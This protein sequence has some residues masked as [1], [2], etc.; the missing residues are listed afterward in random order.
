MKENILNSVFFFSFRFVLEWTT[1]EKKPKKEKEKCVPAGILSE[2]E[3]VNSMLRSETERAEDTTY[4][5]AETE[6]PNKFPQEEGAHHSIPLIILFIFWV[7]KNVFEAEWVSMM[8]RNKN[9]SVVID[10]RDA[11][12]VRLENVKDI[13]MSNYAID[14]E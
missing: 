10:L 7:G 2:L 5:R 11:A 12:S 4:A 13:E 9:C 8:K 1:E 14:F 6:K 3:N